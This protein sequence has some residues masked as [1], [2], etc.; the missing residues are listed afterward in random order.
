MNMKITIFELHFTQFRTQPSLGVSRLPARCNCH[1]GGRFPIHPCAM[2]LGTQK[3]GCDSHRLID[4]LGSP[5]RGDNKS[6]ES[7]T[8][9]ALVFSSFGQRGIDLF[10]GISFTFHG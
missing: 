3:A 9:E 4:L 10:G 7:H 8:V 6:V 2:W 1:V 5:T